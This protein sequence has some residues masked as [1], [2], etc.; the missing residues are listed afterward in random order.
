M[1]EE[2]APAL[3][4]VEPVLRQREGAGAGRGPGV[5]HAHLHE[6]VALAG[7]GEPAA[8]LVGHEPDAGNRRD[9]VVIGEAMLEQV[10]EDRIELDPGHVAE[11]EIF[12][13]QH[14]AAAA[15]ADDRR[16]ALVAD[17]V[18]EAGDVVFEEAELA[19]IAVETVEVAAGRAVDRQMAVLRVGSGTPGAGSHSCAGPVRLGET[20]IREN[21]FQP[22]EDAARVLDLVL[23]HGE[24]EPVR[25]DRG[26]AEREG[27]ERERQRRRAEEP[28]QAGGE[29][30]GRR[31]GAGGA[32]RAL[33]AGGA[34]R[35]Q[36]AHQEQRRDAIHPIHHREDRRGSRRPRP[37]GR[38]HRSAAPAKGCASGRARRRCRGRHKARRG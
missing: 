38:S 5:D 15:D 6:V 10:D 24:L 16:A 23:H 1:I 26:V 20:L 34:G 9:L 25:L 22:D 29:R 35:R 14:V 21:E 36:R 31:R 12:R 30:E 32:V 7:A 33:E 8:R 13:R 4:R 19:E 3:D 2:G 28:R 17:R 18:G 37:A 27:G 11:A